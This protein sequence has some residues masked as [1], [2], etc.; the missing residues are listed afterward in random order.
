MKNQIIGT[1][2]LESFLIENLQGETC[3]WGANTQGLLL[4]TDSGHMSVSI[5]KDVENKSTVD[6][7]NIFDSILFYSGTYSV[8][9]ST[10]KHMVT[11]ASNPNRIGKELL[12]TAILE[13]NLLTLTSPLESFGR[14][15]L[16]WRKIT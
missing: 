7:Q 3:N 6:A 5:N 11:Q 4:Y 15:I 10:I 13:G 14:A 2:T 12:R 9:G 1:W 16:K 8:D